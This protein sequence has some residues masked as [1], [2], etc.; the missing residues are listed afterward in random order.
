MSMESMLSNL[1]QE[2]E[3]EKKKLHEEAESEA[4]QIL[5]KA[6]EEASKIRAEILSKSKRIMDLEEAKAIGNARTQ[7]NRLL[8]E[9]RQKE[10]EKIFQT[11]REK[12]L[13]LSQEVDYSEL[14][15]NLIQ[16]SLIGVSGKIVAEVS[17]ND[18]KLAQDLFKRLKREAQI[19]ANPKISKG[20]I[21]STEDHRL[22]IENTLE[23]R[24]EKALNAL[25]AEVSE[26]LWA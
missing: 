23:A 9:A 4:K 18:V 16:E 8:L 19:Q 15:L 1:E 6:E 7:A 14:L 24:F 3:L 20:V 12:I 13:Q 26:K 21:I 22:R 5:K 17:P 2:A 25:K 10:I 11:S